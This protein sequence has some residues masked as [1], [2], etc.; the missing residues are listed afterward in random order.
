MIKVKYVPTDEDVADAFTKLQL[1]NWMHL[2]VLKL[3][4]PKF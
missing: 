2:L 1:N 3:S 4:E